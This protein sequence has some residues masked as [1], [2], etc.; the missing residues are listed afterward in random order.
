VQKAIEDGFD[1]LGF[2]G[3]AVI[4]IRPTAR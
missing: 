1:Q 4:S 3:A 2:N